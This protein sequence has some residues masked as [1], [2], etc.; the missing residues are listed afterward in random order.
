MLSSTLPDIVARMAVKTLRYATE[1]VRTDGGSVQANARWSEPLAEWSVRSKPYYRSD[2]DYQDTVNLFIA[3][4]GSADTFMFHD[5]E[6][7]T[8]FEV[9]FKDDELNFEPDGN[10]ARLVFALEEVRS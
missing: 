3:A 8:D 9:R 5:I 7:C 6:T 4:L 1:I 10:R 2:D